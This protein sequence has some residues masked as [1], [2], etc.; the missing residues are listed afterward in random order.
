MICCSNSSRNFFSDWIFKDSFSY[1]SI[2]FI[3]SSV[4]LSFFLKLFSWSLE[5]IVFS[6]IFVNSLKIASKSLLRFFISFFCVVWFWEIRSS[7][8]IISWKSILKKV[9]NSCFWFKS[10]L[11]FSFCSSILLFIWVCSVLTSWSFLSLHQMK[12]F[13]YLIHLLFLMIH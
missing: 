9:D 10:F 13:L 2:F 3:S 1:C 11:F 7:F 6:S 4:Y 8:S 5:F 12:F